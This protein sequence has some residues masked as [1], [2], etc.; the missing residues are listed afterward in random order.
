MLRQATVVAVSA[1]ALAAATPLTAVAAQDPVYT[2]TLSDLAVS[3]YDP[4]AYF[5]DGKPVEGSGDHAHEWQGATWRFAS[6]AHLDQFK[7]DPARYA[8]SSAATAPG[9]SARATPPRR[10]RRPGRSSPASST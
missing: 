7:A 2:G 3:G 4:V 10:T 6:P 5:A 9:P 1:I 8:P